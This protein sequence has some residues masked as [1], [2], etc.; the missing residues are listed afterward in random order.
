MN[1][2]PILQRE[3]YL[4]SIPE[5]YVPPTL[6]SHQFYLTVSN[7]KDAQDDRWYR[8]H[9]YD[10]ITEYLRSP[11]MFYTDGLFV[12]K[13]EMNIEWVQHDGVV[14]LSIYTTRVGL[15]QT[16][17]FDEHRFYVENGRIGYLLDL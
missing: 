3:V 9:D 7:R 8:E 10:V 15:L 17:P 1:Q 2:P 11:G 16:Y 12:Y 4:Q 5:R 6:R 13:R 14:E